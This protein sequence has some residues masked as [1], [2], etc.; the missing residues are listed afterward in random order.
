MSTRELE[1]Y[2]LWCHDCNAW[3]AVELSRWQAVQRRNGHCQKHTRHM[4]T[5]MEEADL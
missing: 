1:G 3:L 5:I 2:N 4:V